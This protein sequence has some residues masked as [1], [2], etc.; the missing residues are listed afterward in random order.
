[1]AERVLTGIDTNILVYALNADAPE[2]AAARAFLD[3]RKH[4]SDTVLSELVLVELYVLLRNPAVFR[5]PL[6]SAPAVAMVE[7]FRRHPRWQLVDHD[8]TIMGELWVAAAAPDFARSRIFDARLALGLRVHGV[9]AFAT[10]NVKHFGGC[11]FD[12]VWNPL[13]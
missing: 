7:R 9:R 12:R 13:G 6:G 11:G 5:Q 8:P 2:H 1:M 10:A 3:A 4:D